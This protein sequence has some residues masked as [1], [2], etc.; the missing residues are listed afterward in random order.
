MKTICPNCN[1]PAVKGARFCRSCGT[2]LGDAAPVPPGATRPLPPVGP[3]VTPVPLAGFDT[4]PPGAPRSN[5]MVWWVTGAIALLVVIAGGVAV[6]VVSARGHDP[7]ATP[8]PTWSPTGGYENAGGDV[9]DGTTAASTST[10]TTSTTEPPTAE[11][12]R[13]YATYLEGVIIRSKEQINSFIDALGGLD[14]NC[15]YGA[16]PQ[17]DALQTTIASRQSTLDD[18][19]NASP[20][21]PELA[22]ITE[23]LKEA[24]RASLDADYA[25]GDWLLDI[26]QRALAGGCPEGT[27]HLSTYNAVEAGNTRAG[28]LKQR[29]VDAYNPIARRYGLREFDKAF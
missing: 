8:T 1:T 2:S 27:T 29:V 10:T 24:M 26:D 14:A 5:R 12:E 19:S 15:L 4:P 6:A 28:A 25:Y 7:A 17:Q 16:G 18:V 23:D 13:A 11:A 22:S 20:P 9:D 3:P 21:T